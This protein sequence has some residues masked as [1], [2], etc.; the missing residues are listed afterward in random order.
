VGLTA[1]SS[2]SDPLAA[3]PFDASG[4]L[5]ASVEDGSRTV[6]YDKPLEVSVNDEGGR[7]T[8]VLATDEGGRWVGGRLSDDGTRWR[9]TEPLAAGAKYTVRIRTEDEDGAPGRR[10]LHFATKATHSRQLTV[11]FGP[12]GGGTYGVGQPLVAKLSHAVKKPGQRRVVERGLKVEST[13]AVTG[14]WHWVDDKTLHFRP[15]EYWPAHAAITARAAL[16]G[17]RIR[18][19][20]RGGDSDPLRIRTGDRVISMVDLGAHTM[21]VTKNGE[22]LREIPISAGKPGFRSRTGVKIVLGK[23][24]LVRMRSTSIGIPAGSSDSYDLQVRWATRLTQSGEFVHAAPWSAGAQGV[25]NT[26]HGCTG[27][28]TENAKWFFGLAHK[29]DVVKY[30]NG[31]GDHMP[32]FGNGFGDWNMTWAE[33]SRGGGSRSSREEPSEPTVQA[34]RLRPRL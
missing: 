30:V 25:A 19:G 20:L 33:W 5:T 9:S 27:M 3:A 21:T 12:E 29:G 32:V 2:E 28:S 15:Q 22:E 6:A 23:S 31:D 1:C 26:S 34:A 24:S 7:I 11:S 4:Q 18:D 16:D 14:A 13:P 8:D 17:V 10:V